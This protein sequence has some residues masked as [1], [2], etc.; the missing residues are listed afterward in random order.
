VATLVPAGLQQRLRAGAI[1][2]TTFRAASEV[3]TEALTW[4]VELDTTDAV[5]QRYTLVFEPVEG[6]LVS[7]VRR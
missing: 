1:R 2:E 6:R 7:L 4:R 3:P 5:P